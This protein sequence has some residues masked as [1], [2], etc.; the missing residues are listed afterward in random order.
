MRENPSARTAERVAILTLLL[1]A[2]GLRVAGLDSQELRGDEAFGYFF[3]LRQIPEMVTATV[4]LQ[5]PHPVAAY[6]IQHGWLAVAGHSEFALRLLGVCFGVL[7]VALVGRLGDALK[8]TRLSRVLATGL[9]AVSPYLI[10]HAQDARMYSMSLALTLAATVCM[11][12]WLDAPPAR[13]WRAW[14]PAYVGLS[15]LALHTHYFAI[16][17]LLA[18]YLFVVGTG[19]LDR[20][21]RGAVLPWI[22]VQAAVGLLYVPWVIRAAET[23][24]GYGGNGDSPRFS[25]AM[26]RALAV[27]STGESTVGQ[28]QIGVAVLALTL[29][30]LGVVRL[31]GQGRA[32]RRAASLLLLYLGAPLMATW[33]SAQQRPIFDE[34]YLVAAAPP[35]LLLL[36][37]AVGEENYTGARRGRVLAWVPAGL[38]IVLLLG[39]LTGLNR[40][41]Y[42]PA[43]SKNRGWR[44][45]AA[46]MTRLSAGPPPEESRIAQN[47]PDPTLWYYYQ[48]PVDHVVLPPGPAD[49]PG[50]R[51]SAQELAQHGVGRI[52]LP[53]QPAP[54]WDPAGVA[55]TALQAAGFQPAWSEQVGVWPVT[56]Y[57][58][59]RTEFIPLP[60]AA[61][62]A[63][64]TQILGIGGVDHQ[65]APG[66]LMTPELLIGT[67]DTTPDTARDS[68]AALAAQRKISLQ[69][70]G[71]DGALL[72]QDDR[73]LSAYLAGESIAG[74]AVPASLTPGTYALQLVLYDGETGVREPLLDGRDGLLLHEWSFTP[75]STE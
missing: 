60:A 45:L 44:E 41:V 71:P 56:V 73:L 1:L 3:S 30:A 62:F 11:V 19:V 50:A 9:A 58:A 14:T 69:F 70:L 64:G 35:L 52:L 34:R 26:R 51:H 75:A 22:G 72:A 12:E 43:F 16:F 39:M 2:F 36:A 4:A 28:P 49:A 61:T 32:Q 67:G 31:F 54:N 74:L 17:V 7:S 65:L 13:R 46:A 27:M 40:Q 20:R 66:G 59:P 24:T 37:A 29:I 42:D 10:W 47:F 21:Y 8:L 5:E 63:D 38:L 33:F 53:S 48:G 25:E 6:V 15:L 23:L 18:H 55:A 57:V 68:G